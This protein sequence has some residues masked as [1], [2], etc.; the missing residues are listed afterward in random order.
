MKKHIILLGALTISSLAYSQ[1]GIN[2]ETPKATL[3][4]VASPDMPE[5]IDGF[6]A[7]RLEG[8][9]LSAKDAL[10]T[11]DQLGAIVYAKSAA[12]PTTAKTVNVT[13]AGYYYFDGTVWVKVGKEDGI[14]PWYVEN[15]TTKAND[16][17]QN[18]YQ[19]GNVGVGDFTGSAT[20]A[21]L[22]VK[23]NVLGVW[24]MGDYY[25]TIATA[26]QTLGINH[27]SMTEGGQLPI[28]LGGTATK[29]STFNQWLG[30]TYIQEGDGDD[31][32]N[33]QLQPNQME[34][35]SQDGSSVSRIRN[36][37]VGGGIAF[38][39]DDTLTGISSGYKFPTKQGMAGQVLTTDGASSDTAQL[40]WSTPVSGGSTEPW[41][42]AANNQPAT[43]N[44][45]D[46][47]QM[48]RVGIGAKNPITALHIIN[49]DKGG[50]DDDIYIQSYNNGTYASAPSLYLQRGRGTVATPA[51]TQNGDFLS[52]I[53][54]RGMKADG[55]ILEGSYIR[56]IY[57]GDGTNAAADLTFGTCDP[58]A[59]T[60]ANRMLIDQNGDV[61][62]ASRIPNDLTTK[63]IT[64][65]DVR[66]S[67]RGGIPSALEVDGTSPVGANSI[68]VG[69][70]NIVQGP[71]SAVFG[72]SNKVNSSTGSISNDNL[73]YGSTNIIEKTAFSIVGGYNNQ[74]NASSG[75]AV[76]G[77]GNIISGGGTGTVF[78]QSNTTNASHVFMAGFGN[79]I[80][81]TTTSVSS[82]AL[83]INNTINSGGR[84]SVIAGSTNTSNG[85]SAAVFGTL[86]TNAA[87]FSLIVGKE[88]TTTATSIGAF[89]TG[90][91]NDIASTRGGVAFGYDN[92]ITTGYDHF[93]SGAQNNVSGYSYN[94]VIG[95][96][97]D[98]SGNM[99]Q[100]FG[101]F[102]NVSGDFSFAAGRNNTASHR[103]AMAI[104]NGATSTKEQQLV[105]SFAGGIK[106]QGGVPEYADNAAAIAG[107]LEAG[108]IYRTG[109]IMKIVH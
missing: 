73:I 1:V 41:Y 39:F 93:V 30:S 31:I 43:E 50:N 69:T 65:L 48:G 90:T 106:V 95:Y 2:T 23:G 63:P 29:F 24:N 61:L 86:N 54:F 83:G 18:I 62:I 46:I 20:Q 38:L 88:N 102:N 99:A 12:S 105:L 76:G 72:S 60:C 5:R 25:S 52:Q 56:S 81:G 101:S 14:E 74:V 26:D 3:D 75:W 7:P 42:N 70:N 57:R 35:R 89:A 8:N 100:A 67:I 9:E 68:A 51:A 28:T 94:A 27:I 55:S 58:N 17:N 103:D 98:M 97:N 45:Q 85:E 77:Q 37:H 66:G 15:T 104:G 36:S 49:D 16:N 64:K 78:G 47:Y 82:V 107:G 53:G 21:N 32:T 91:L 87:N 79:K 11:A 6:I 80:D 109:D 34:L 19:N 22:H 96:R 40:Y 84:Y 13:Q 108:T 59:T 71:N 92:N 4:V 44:T 10:Y 33:I